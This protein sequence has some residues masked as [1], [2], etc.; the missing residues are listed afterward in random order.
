MTSKIIQQ[1]VPGGLHP[2]SPLIAW[3]M[4]NFQM[5]FS[6]RTITILVLN[7]NGIIFITMTLGL[8]SRSRLLEIIGY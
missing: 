1:G 5:V 2:E 6:Y 7:I 4:T 8:H 3:G